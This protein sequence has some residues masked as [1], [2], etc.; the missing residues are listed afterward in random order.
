MTKMRAAHHRRS[1][2]AEIRD[3]LKTT[4]LPVDRLRIGSTVAILGLEVG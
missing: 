2:E 3:I 1:K 4:I